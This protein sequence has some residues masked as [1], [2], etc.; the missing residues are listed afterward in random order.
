[1]D[2]QPPRGTSDLL[3]PG[4]DRMLRLYRAAGA[5][6]ELYGYSYVETAILEPTELFTATSGESSD[7]VRKEKYTFEDRSGRSLTLRPE[8]TAPVMRA[9]LAKAHELPPLFKAYYIEP[10]WRYGRPQAGRLR[11]F[12][13][14]GVEVIGTT[15]PGGDVEVIALADTF[16]RERGL[17]RFDLRINSIGD[18]RC[19][20][21]YRGE[22][23]SYLEANRDRLVDEHRTRFQEN[24][25]RVL[26]C[27]DDACVAVS[28]GAPK[29]SDRLCD[30]CREH[31]A[32]VRSGLEGESV[33][34]V[35]D[36]TLVRGLDYYTR[37]AFEFGS[38]ELSP[39]QRTVC[40]GGRYDGLA[41]A[42]GAAP[43]PGVGF[44]M[45]LDR[46]MLAQD[47]EGVA[48]AVGGVPRCFVVAIGD[49]AREW[50]SRVV[51][52]L[53]ETGISAASGF[54]PRPL[55]A[56][57]RMAGRS[58]AGFAAIVGEKEAGAGTVTLRRL[59]DGHQEELGLSNAAAW[60]HSQSETSA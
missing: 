50:A 7:V 34:H 24:P 5:L 37:T 28:S 47:G 22:L 54:E 43:T 14:F 30:P 2:L 46:V 19:R 58:G 6:A 26:D 29:I 52:T 49:A 57:L 17:S 10:E 55:K 39:G 20:P 48:E 27:L 12:R 1:M 35:L 42:M 23:S 21:A 9:Y 33:P 8:G 51:R 16:L 53:R 25:L 31:F 4:S 18:E 59:S 36:T 38:G 60:I 56:Q 45:G 44:G 41:E 13:V 11:E 40:G 32:G 3:P 15:D